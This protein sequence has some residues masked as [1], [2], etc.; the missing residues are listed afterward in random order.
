MT[1][2]L[3][4]YV[5]RGRPETLI[6]SL[7]MSQD[8][9]ELSREMTALAQEIVPPMARIIDAHLARLPMPRADEAMS[10]DVLP[11]DFAYVLALTLDHHCPHWNVV[12]KAVMFFEYLIDFRQEAQVQRLKLIKE[13]HERIGT[14]PSVG[15]DGSLDPG[16]FKTIVPNNLQD[17]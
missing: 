4:D 6:H 5:G 17:N 15:V 1:E 14:P 11:S 12:Q 13:Y 3:S 10:V 16:E 7:F 9:N 8:F 2:N